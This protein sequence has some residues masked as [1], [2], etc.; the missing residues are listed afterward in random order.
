MGDSSWQQGSAT[1]RDA[2][3]HDATRG[4]HSTSRTTAHSRLTHH[5]CA[6]SLCLAQMEIGN[7]L[8][9]RSLGTKNQSR[10]K[11]TQTMS[12]F[13]SGYSTKFLKYFTLR[14]E[15]ET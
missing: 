1:L 4:A 11:Q 13:V 2:A 12:M 10:E 8:R 7:K 15:H 5:L 9:R 6:H 3:D 14:D